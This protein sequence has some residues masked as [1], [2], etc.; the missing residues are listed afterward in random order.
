[1]YTF[2]INQLVKTLQ[3][4]LEAKHTGLSEY[5]LLKQL[6][7]EQHPLFIS[8]NLSDVLSLFRSHFV[9]FHALYLLRDNLRSAGQLDL[10]ISPLHICLQPITTRSSTQSQMPN[11]SDPLRAYYLDLDNLS[12]TDREAVEQ[13]L[14]SSLASLQPSQQLS[15]ALAELGIEQPLHTLNSEDLRS[16]YRKLVSRHHPDR[17]GCT[18]RLQ[19]INQAMDMVRAYQVSRSCK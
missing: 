2:K 5:E 7:S 18:E 12:A 1:M 10:K 14:N 6:I 9:L 4:L 3:R 19:R 13:L 8:A 15:D 16:H 11:L 17:G